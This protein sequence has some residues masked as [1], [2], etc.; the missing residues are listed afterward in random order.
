VRDSI[1]SGGSIE[2]IHQYYLLNNGAG[3]DMMEELFMSVPGALE[4]MEVEQQQEPG[5][6]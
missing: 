4:K 3:S 1:F 5:E 6:G 2:S